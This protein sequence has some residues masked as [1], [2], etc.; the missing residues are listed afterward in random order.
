LPT[1]I[2]YVSSGMMRN[3]V[4]FIKQVYH[5]FAQKGCF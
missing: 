3:L 2:T 4:L 1:A 5:F